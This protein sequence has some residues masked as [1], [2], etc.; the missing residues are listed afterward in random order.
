MSGDELPDKDDL[1]AYLDSVLKRDF[2]DDEETDEEE[3]EETPRA[4]GREPELGFS[5]PW[6]TQVRAGPRLSHGHRCH[7]HQPIAGTRGNN[8][9]HSSSPSR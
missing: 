8:L 9:Q 2:P 3:T 6:V 1:N 7:Q 4:P 5:L